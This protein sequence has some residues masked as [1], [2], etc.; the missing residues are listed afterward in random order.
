[1]LTLVAASKINA[2]TP[3]FVTIPST[4]GIRLPS[5]GMDRQHRLSIGINALAGQR[6]PIQLHVATLGTFTAGVVLKYRSVVNN[7]T[8]VAQGKRDK[9][10][11]LDLTFTPTMTILPG[12][13][14]VVKLDRFQGLQKNSMVT[15][16]SHT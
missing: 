3:L 14:V 12:E 8:G 5:R 7:Y 11:E 10:T 15:K 9:P 16:Q 13:R 6:S 4:M 2:S 1:M